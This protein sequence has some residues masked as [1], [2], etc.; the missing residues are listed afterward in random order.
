[1]HIDVEWNKERYHLREVVFGKV[2]FLKVRIKIKSMEICLL[3]REKAGLGDNASN[4]SETVGKIEVM[5]GCP[6]RDEAIPIRLFLAQFDNLTPTYS[7]VNNQFSTRY[8]LNIVIIDESGRRY[9][10]QQDIVLYRR[11]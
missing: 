6:V 8:S 3:R 10:K 7:N 5:D 11:D 1:L 4:D 2:S 9:F